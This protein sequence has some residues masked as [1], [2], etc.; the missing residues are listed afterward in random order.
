MRFKLLTTQMKINKGRWANNTDTP[1]SDSASG[2]YEP[3]VR[4]VVSLR[5]SH[6]TFNAN[7][8]FLLYL[9]SPKTPFI[10][11]KCGMS[12]VAF[13]YAETFIYVCPTNWSIFQAIVHCEENTKWV[14]DLC[15]Y[16]CMWLNT[17]ISTKS[18]RKDTAFFVN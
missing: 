10:R 2:F 16:V 12:G 9:S 8:I 14:N 17:R 3:A 5:P 4:K 1:R 7:V 15:V 18:R 13:D 11:R 6:E